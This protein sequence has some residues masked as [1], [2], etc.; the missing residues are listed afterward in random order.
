MSWMEE[1]KP[2]APPAIPPRVDAVDLA[3]MLADAKSSGRP[4]TPL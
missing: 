2:P 1:D 3:V 4:L